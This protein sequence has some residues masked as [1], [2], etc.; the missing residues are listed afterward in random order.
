MAEWLILDKTT[1]IGSDEVT[2][3][4]GSYEEL[5]DRLRNLVFTTV[6][7]RASDTC[8][9]TQKGRVYYLYVNPSSVSVAY[10]GGTRTITINT[11]DDWILSGLPEWVTAD[12]DSGT[13]GVTTVTL[14]F[15][16]NAGDSARTGSVTVE[17]EHVTK[18]VAI[19]QRS[20]SQGDVV[21]DPD[22]IDAD[23]CSDGEYT[24]RIVTDKCWSFDPGDV[25]TPTGKF[26]IYGTYFDTSLNL[27]IIY[28][29]STDRD[30]GY[31]LATRNDGNNTWSASNPKP[32]YVKG[33]IY[34]IRLW[35]T[36]TKYVNINS[37]VFD[38]NNF[39]N[40]VRL[41]NCDYLF[42]LKDAPM[43]INM[44]ESIKFIN[45]DFSE[46]T[47]MVSMF[48][49]C[50]RAKEIST[51]GWNTAK[52]KQMQGMFSGCGSLEELDLSDF[53]FA[54]VTNLS[55]MLNGC[56]SLK[57]LDLS[58]MGYIGNVELDGIFMDCSSLASLNLSNLGISGGGYYYT[59]MF[60]GCDN[61]VE[62]N[63]T[64]ATDYTKNKI[65]LQLQHD[66]SAYTWTLSNGI[67]TRS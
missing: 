54:S 41:T 21:I 14:T 31:Q 63:L 57:S 5:E 16:A 28:V 46:V 7:G 52:V 64:N 30:S 25:P 39:T 35:I 62:V 50:G 26:P 45:P 8:K 47:S 60:T 23:G 36:G 40:P 10:T 59:D 56:S 22:H 53:S 11:N 58:M 43:A 37:I 27:P 4:C 66:L 38:F 65:L 44:L 61:L 12:K 67:I 15:T 19:Y 51:K 1:G 48:S 55:D 13:S 34:R 33:N 29:Y 42:G 24:V 49:G 18:S 3:T 9:V 32:E 17:G 6:N 2:I 20:E